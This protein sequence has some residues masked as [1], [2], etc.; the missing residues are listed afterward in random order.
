M[1][2]LNAKQWI[3]CIIIV[4]VFTFGSQV[5]SGG[6]SGSSNTSY[7]SKTGVTSYK[8]LSCGRTFTDSDN[9]S[10]IRRTNMC[11]NCYKL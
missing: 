9:R 4:L 5:T 2:G 6:G 3:I 1:G 8:C 10:S 7:N 11:K